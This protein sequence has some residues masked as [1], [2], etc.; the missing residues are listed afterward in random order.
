MVKARFQ[1]DTCSNANIDIDY[2]GKKP[3]VKFKYPAGKKKTPVWGYSFLFAFIIWLVV[4]GIGSLAIAGYIEYTAPYFNDTGDLTQE[5]KF[6]YRYTECSNFYD[7]NYG[8]V[9]LATCTDKAINNSLLTYTG[10]LHHENFGRF[11]GSKRSLL[12]LVF[13]FL[14]PWFFLSLVI[15]VVFGE[16][17]RRDFPTYQIKIDRI[18]RQEHFSRIFKPKDFEDNKELEIPLFTNIFLDYEA[19]KEFSKYLK[20]IKIE[21][22]PFVCN[23]FK[24]KKLTKKKNDGLW[25]ARFIFSEIPKTGKLEVKWR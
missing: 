20:R 7:E 2:K 18:T 23:V 16:N 6:Q 9:I 19:T 15:K 14:I 12:F 24:G 3:C 17:I 5:D 4:F 1:E 13:Y 25:R 22:H 21:E 10:V 11:D 8:E